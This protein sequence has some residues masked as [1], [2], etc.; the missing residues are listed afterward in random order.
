MFP[1]SEKG[2]LPNTYRS[3]TASLL[4]RLT[5]RRGDN[6]VPA[7]RRAVVPAAVPDRPPPERGR[8]GGDVSLLLAHP[9]GRRPAIL[10]LQLDALPR[11][12]PG[13]RRPHLRDPVPRHRRQRRP[14]LLVPDDHGNR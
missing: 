14:A 4:P 3:G 9:A 5:P 10:V 13:L 1:D 8:V 12:R 7:H 2:A 11:G 6:D